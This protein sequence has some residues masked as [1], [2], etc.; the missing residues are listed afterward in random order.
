MACR[1]SASILVRSASLLGSVLLSFALAAP[2]AE[3]RIGIPK[4]VKDAVGK[5]AEQK[6]APQQKTA[7]EEPVVFDDVVLE[8]NE[9]R[10]TAVLAAC[11]RVEKVSA[12]RPPLAAKLEKAGEERQKLLDKHEEKFRED[13]NKR[14]E[15]ETCRSEGFNAVRDRK[16]QE[17]QQRALTDPALR[18]K[19]TKVAQEYNAAAMSGDST[20][21]RKAQ[22]AMFAEVL[23]SKEDSANVVQE[24]GPMP[25]TSPEEKKLD[26]LDKEIA[27]LHEQ[28]RAVDE[29]VA[30]EQTSAQGGFTREQWGMAVERIQMF[31]SAKKQKPKDAPRGFSDEEIEAMEK[32]LEELKSATCWT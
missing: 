13:R 23:P 12:G 25:P 11:T 3:A 16:T 10:V 19:F 4:T 17:Y 32:R 22:E 5:T 6:A 2:A 24:C 28:I 29:K 20:A 26:A 18:E 9:E 31:L 1:P 21:I 7:P 30:A 15:I 27:S 8:L 14:S